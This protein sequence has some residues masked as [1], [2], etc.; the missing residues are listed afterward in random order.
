MP[1]CV[2][3]YRRGRGGEILMAPFLGRECFV[4]HSRGEVYVFKIFLTAASG[5]GELFCVIRV[6]VNADGTR[7]GS[8]RTQSNGTNVGF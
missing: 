1:G 4:L 6:G 5:V 7:S 8:Y 3:T 2:L